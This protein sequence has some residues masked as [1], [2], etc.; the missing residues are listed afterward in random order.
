MPV[1]A[2]AEK[3]GTPCYIYSKAAILD[4]LGNADQQAMARLMIGKELPHCKHGA[5]QADGELRLSLAGLSHAA[6]APFGTDPSLERLG[7]ALLVAAVVH[8]AVVFGVSFS[9]PPRPAPGP[10]TLDVILVEA[11]EWCDRVSEIDTTLRSP[12]KVADLVV[13]ILR[14][15]IEMPPGD[16]DWTG[17]MEFDP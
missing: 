3:F 4:N 17:E 10:S 12:E 9:P 8:A 2:A 7:R 1:S 5:A 14:R 13:G 15:E 16:I 6:R 11:M